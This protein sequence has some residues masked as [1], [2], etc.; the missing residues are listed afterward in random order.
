MYISRINI[1]ISKANI[2]LTQTSMRNYYETIVAP[3]AAK[4]ANSSGWLWYIIIFAAM[5]WWK[6]FK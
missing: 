4:S 2:L 6:L 3:R 1:K 5:I